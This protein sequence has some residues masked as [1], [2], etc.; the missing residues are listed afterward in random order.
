[1]G[2]GLGLAISREIIV[3]KHGGKITC[4][5]KEG[6]GTEFAIALPIKHQYSSKPHNH[7]ESL[8]TTAE[9]SHRVNLS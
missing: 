8:A 7:F 3:E 1:V 9:K 6:V 5:S 4:N 2:T